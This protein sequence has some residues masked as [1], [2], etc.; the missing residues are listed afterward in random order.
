MYLWLNKSNNSS[1]NASNIVDVWLVG[2]QSNADGRVSITLAPEWFDQDTRIIPN[3]RMWNYYLN[4]FTH[5]KFGAGSGY[6]N[7]SWS[8]NYTSYAFDMVALHSLQE[9]LNK[10]IHIVKCSK[11]N[12][13]LIWDN[14][15][16]TWTTD[17]NVENSTKM[18]QVMQGRITNARNYLAM[19]GKVANFKGMLWHQGESDAQT[20]EE[21]ANYK[22]AMQD[23]ISKVREYTWNENLFVVMGTI[24]T[25]SAD[26]TL[27]MKQ[28]MQEIA[29]EDPNVY[30]VDVGAATLMDAYHFDAASTE[31]FGNSV[32]EIIKDL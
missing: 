22:P 17:F 28:D 11:G 6:S 32:F 30:L 10:E 20:P 16:G 5:W 18:L 25:T 2:G 27:Q 13:G 23:L 24:P 4:E 7:G 8:E 15:A 21:L 26:Y 14:A 31:S 9:Y 1:N 12:T 19:Q 3:C 29:A